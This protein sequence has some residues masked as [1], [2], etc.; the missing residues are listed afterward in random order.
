MS[1]KA[2]ESVG[3]A[4]EL[5]GVAA[6]STPPVSLEALESAGPLALTVV[7]PHASSGASTGPRAA[8][9]LLAML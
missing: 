5:S 8:K 1:G 2:P 4:S 9:N 6:L 7:P 3:V